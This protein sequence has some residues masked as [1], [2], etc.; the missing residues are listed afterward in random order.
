M[1]FRN[2]GAII[3]Q[4][5][6]YRFLASYFNSGQQKDTLLDL[7]CGPRPYRALYQHAFKKTIG[8]EHPSSHFPKSEIDIYCLAT[9]IPLDDNTID[10]VLCTEVM[11]DIA[12]PTMML[13][14]IHRILKPGGELILTTPFVTPIVDGEYDH[15]RFTCY[16]LD[17]LL[18]KS[19]FE[20]INIQPVGD[21]FAATVTLWIKPWLKFF[22]VIAKKTGIRAI[23]SIYNPLMFI[24]TTLPQIMYLLT[25]KLPGFKHLYSKFSYG[26][27]G[28]I[29]H[30]RKVNR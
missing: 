1:Q 17:Y 2:P 19:G 12:E 6:R 9:D 18:K 7:G 4:T 28:F 3:E 10:T 22:N 29:S 11:H 23:Y 13:N 8:A 24:F 15:Y 14:E 26:P 30:V 25:M 16:G 21:V 5:L 27:I 20:I